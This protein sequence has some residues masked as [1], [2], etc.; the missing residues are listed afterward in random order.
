MRKKNSL[1]CYD[2]YVASFC[3]TKFHIEWECSGLKPIRGP[4]THWMYYPSPKL[5]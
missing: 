5:E 2:V 3:T 4:V 1:S